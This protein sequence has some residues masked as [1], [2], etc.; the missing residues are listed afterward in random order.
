MQMIA[1][2][3]K[4]EEH[5][6]SHGQQNRVVMSDLKSICEVSESPSTDPPYSLSSSQSQ[7]CGDRS[8]GNNP[9]SQFIR[10]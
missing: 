7:Q 4:M 6:N 1:F 9:C 10:I 8:N 2:A 5:D 3:N